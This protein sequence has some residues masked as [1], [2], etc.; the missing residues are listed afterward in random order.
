MGLLKY[1]GAV[2]SDDAKMI[3]FFSPDT[4]TPSFKRPIY[5]QIMVDVRIIGKCPLFA[6]LLM[7]GCVRKIHS[8]EK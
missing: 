4:S 8:M 2:M 3:F 6:L 7:D 1:G 5:L